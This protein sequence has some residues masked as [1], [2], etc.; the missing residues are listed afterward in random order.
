MYKLIIVDSKELQTGIKKEMSEHGMSEKEARK[1]AIDH[2]KEN[3]HYYSIADSVGLED[4]TV[5]SLE[6][7]ATGWAKKP[8]GGSTKKAINGIPTGK[9]FPFTQKSGRLWKIK[10]AAK[11]GPVVAVGAGFGGPG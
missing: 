9:K 10:K 3:P 2:L 4:E 1:T 11:S 5:E 8:K 7:Y 6:E